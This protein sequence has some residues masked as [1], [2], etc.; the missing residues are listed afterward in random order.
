MNADMRWRRNVLERLEAL[1]RLIADL[2]PKE[3][4][5]TPVKESRPACDHSR[6]CDYEVGGKWSCEYPKI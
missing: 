4:A 2:G 5:P 1:E 6:G 3:K